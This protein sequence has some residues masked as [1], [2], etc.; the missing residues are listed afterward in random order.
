MHNLQYVSKIEDKKN[1]KNDKNVR[2]YCCGMIWR[3]TALGRV[4]ENK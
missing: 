3:L 4:G 1:D 2:H